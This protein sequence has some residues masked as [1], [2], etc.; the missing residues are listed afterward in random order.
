MK[1]RKPRTICPPDGTAW[2]RVVDMEEA[3]ID[4]GYLSLKEAERVIKFLS[5]FIA[6]SKEKRA[7]ME[8]KHRCVETGG[9]KS[10]KC[11]K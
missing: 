2:L 8:E 11:D 10:P 5:T 1:M 6:W 9:C 7:A 3:H 4:G